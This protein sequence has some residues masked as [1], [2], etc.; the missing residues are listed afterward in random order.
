MISCKA[1]LDAVINSLARSNWQGAQASIAALGIVDRYV[2]DLYNRCERY[3]L[4]YLQRGTAAPV[5]P[6]PDDPGPPGSTGSPSGA[7]Q[8]SAEKV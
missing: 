3:W 1:Q 8:Q 7:V 4:L 5:A 6:S 2:C